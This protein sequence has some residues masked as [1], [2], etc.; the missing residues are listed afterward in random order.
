MW[1]S[2]TPS[3]VLIKLFSG[4]SRSISNTV[5]SG[6]LDLAPLTSAHCDAWSE[7][8]SRDVLSAGDIINMSACD[9]RHLQP[10]SL[11]TLHNWITAHGV[12]PSQSKPCMFL[13]RGAGFHHDADSYPDE[14]FCVLWL[15]EDTKWDLLFPFTGHRIPLEY[16]TV[17]IFDSAQPHGLVLRGQS[18]F[19]RDLFDL[20]PTGIFVSQ[21]FDLTPANRKLLGIKKYSRKGIASMPIL[22]D[23]AFRQDLDPESGTWHIRSILVA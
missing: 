14:A 21:D 16:G 9:E 4:G 18:T 15:A 23:G 3:D 22:S 12:V 5:V 10:E 6:R 19:D 13:T 8:I 11:N 7:L 2:I 20:E 1:Q 17:V